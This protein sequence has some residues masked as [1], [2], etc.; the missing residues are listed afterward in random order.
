MQRYFSQR[1]RPLPDEAIDNYYAAA[2][3]LEESG[4]QDGE[5]PPV[6]GED[7]DPK[8]RCPRDYFRRGL[9]IR[10]VAQTDDGTLFCVDAG[11]RHA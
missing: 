6:Q 3:I 7:Y 10:G 4:A 2:K 11:Y 9:V 5:L 8:K 1:G